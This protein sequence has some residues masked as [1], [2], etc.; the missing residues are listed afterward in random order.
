MVLKLSHIW[1]DPPFKI[2]DHLPFGISLPCP[3]PIKLCDI[4]KIELLNPPT[5][6]EQF[7]LEVLQDP[8]KIVVPKAR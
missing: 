4:P 2:V 3:T 8:P 5:I 6:T 1:L 7:A